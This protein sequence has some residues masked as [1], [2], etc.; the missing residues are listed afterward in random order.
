MRAAAIHAGAEV[1]V[2]DKP[3]G[4]PRP[5]PRPLGL[6]VGR[7]LPVVWF[8]EMN[9]GATHDMTI[10][11]RLSDDEQRR[12]AERAVRNGRD[13]AEYVRLLIERDIE[14]PS[15][16]DRAR[17]PPSAIRSKRVA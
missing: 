15:A 11:I 12:L 10:T 2:T 5:F 8:V 17:S 4:L 3:E 1:I 7:R 6:C 14:G 16:V 13:V 9:R